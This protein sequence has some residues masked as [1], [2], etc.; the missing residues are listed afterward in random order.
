MDRAYTVHVALILVGF[1]GEMHL[2][3]PR[4]CMYAAYPEG[5][6]TIFMLNSYEHEISFANKYENVKKCWH[7]HIY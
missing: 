7:F 2:H 1:T 6:N 5:Y 4:L 3:K